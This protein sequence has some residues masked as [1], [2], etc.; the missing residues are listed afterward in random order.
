MAWVAALFSPQTLE[1][2]LLTHTDISH[3]QVR[4]LEQNHVG[5]TDAFKRAL[6]IH[7]RNQTSG[8]GNTRQVMRAKFQ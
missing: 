3:A 6:L 7:F 4:T 1:M 5:N 2:V 8:D